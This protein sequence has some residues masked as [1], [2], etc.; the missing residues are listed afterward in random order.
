MQGVLANYNGPSV[1]ATSTT[2][3]N[4]P[5]QFIYTPLTLTSIVLRYV[6]LRHVVLCRIHSSI[7]FD[8]FIRLRIASRRLVSWRRVVEHC[9]TGQGRHL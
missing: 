4:V 6:A 8:V 3:P 2:N 7:M 9:S 5:G 1:H